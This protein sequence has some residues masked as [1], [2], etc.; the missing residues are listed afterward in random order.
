MARFFRFS[1]CV[2][3]LP[4]FLAGCLTLPDHKAKDSQ[5]VYERSESHVRSA[6]VDQALSPEEQHARAKALVDPTKMN[7]N[8]KYVK[9]AKDVERSQ[10]YKEQPTRVA[11][12]E[13]DLNIVQKEFKGLKSAVRRAEIAPAS[14][15]LTVQAHVEAV[16]LG[17][18]P[19]KTRLV[20]DLD[21]P[22]E[23]NF[24]VNNAQ[25]LLVI[26]LPGT[27]W[28]TSTE[29]VFGGSKMLR[30][31]AAKDAASGGSVV[32]VKLRGPAKVIA[33]AKLGKNAAGKHRIFLDVAPL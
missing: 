11:R 3:Y 31:Y 33:S 7:Q 32:V 1:L 23:F 22:A 21:R 12:L 26:R 15:N 25:N 13:Q 30:A 6:K 5:T 19:N 18:Y 28:S 9:N 20:F 14:G 8:N 27:G 16:R 4:L 29:Y 17:E 2:L 24:D 10:L